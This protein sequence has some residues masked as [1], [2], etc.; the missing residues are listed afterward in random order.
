M[1]A[2]VIQIR[3]IVVPTDFSGHADA[4]LEYAVFLAKTHGASIHL[5]HAYQLPIRPTPSEFA[6]SAGL[7]ADIQ[8]YAQ[9]GV[10]ALRQKVA[11]QGIEASAEAVEGP[12]SVRIVELAEHARADLIVMGTRGLT[13]VKHVLLGSVAERTVR[14]APCPVLTI[15]A[16]DQP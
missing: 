6:Y 12:A 5:V 4:A 3:K 7:F 11:A 9:Q 14:H 2:T 8:K 13:G 16:K 10:D 15:K 1:E